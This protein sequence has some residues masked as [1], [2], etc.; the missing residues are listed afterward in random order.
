MTREPDR[1]G[2][3]GEW[4][5]VADAWLTITRPTPLFFVSAESKGLRHPVSSLDATLMG[6]SVSVDFKGDLGEA[7][8]GNGEWWPPGVFVRL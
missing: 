5:L 7:E 2:A 8:N 3:A 1:V 6:D 4:T